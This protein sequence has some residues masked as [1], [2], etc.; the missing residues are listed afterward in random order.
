MAGAPDDPWVV[1]LPVVRGG[2]RKVPGGTGCSMMDWNR[3]A[4]AKKMPAQRLIS[5][6]EVRK[7]N[8]VNDMWMVIHGKVYDVTL[9]ARH[10]PGG[11]GVL[12]TCAGRDAT[13]MYNKYHPWVQAEAMMGAF[14]LGTYSKTAEY[15]G[16]P[17]Y[18]P[19]PK[20]KL[21][22][23]PGELL[24][25]EIVATRK[26]REELWVIIGGK[27]Y[28]VTQFAA[29]HPGGV[30]VLLEYGGKDATKLFEKY[31]SRK[32]AAH[33]EQFL[34]GELAG[35]AAPVKTSVPPAAA[36]AP[37]GYADPHL[38]ALPPIELTV[39]SAPAAVNHDSFRLSLRPKD[40][41]VAVPLCGHIRLYN[42]A[43]DSR[44]YT[45]IA[46]GAVLEFIV[47]EYTGGQLSP[48]LRGLKEGSVVRADRP[49]ASDFT[50][51]EA[52]RS[53]VLVAGGTGIAPFLPLLERLGA[54]GCAAVVHVMWGNK[55]PDDIL[56]VLEDTPWWR[57]D[58]MQVRH[59]FSAVAAGAAPSHPTHVHTRIDDAACQSFLPPGP[60]D[61]ATVAL[62]CGPPD[63]NRALGGLLVAKG[64]LRTVLLD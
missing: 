23:A 49:A 20:P 19:K 11:E 44:R 53:Y 50:F 6:A 55:T 39:V 38:P 21:P 25:K 41:P 51:N 8:K 43:G 34:L 5:E 40:G 58:R 4:A 9:F 64:F 18:V 47:K 63:F 12:L 35:A 29:S 3:M 60:P 36:N 17:P 30:N 33:A 56:L 10:H 54:E 59:H 1:D 61:D 37:P 14:C 2:R 26:T 48:W 15:D 32:A 57:P 27:V 46:D 42:S 24:T 62:V 45:P 31:H 52:D 16:P 13:V 7:H 28:D 22:W